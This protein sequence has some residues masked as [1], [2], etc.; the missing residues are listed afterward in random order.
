MRFWVA[1]VVI[2]TIGVD[3]YNSPKISIAAVGQ[4]QDS[5]GVGLM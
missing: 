1:L 2:W 4:A 3:K 5:Q